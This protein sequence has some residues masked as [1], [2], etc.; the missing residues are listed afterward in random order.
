MDKDKY[1]EDLQ[2]ENQKLKKEKERLERGTTPSRLE[3]YQQSNANLKE[4]NK[5]L[6]QEIK[7]MKAENKKANTLASK[8]K[9]ELEEKGELEEEVKRLKKQSKK[10][11]INLEHLD[12]AQLELYERTIRDFNSHH[13][14]KI[15]D[16]PEDGTDNI[17]FDHFKDLCNQYP[18]KDLVREGIQSRINH[19][20]D[21]KRAE[22]NTLKEK[23]ELL[24]KVHQAQTNNPDSW[25]EE[26]DDKIISFANTVTHDDIEKKIVSLNSDIINIGQWGKL[27]TTDILPHNN[28]EMADNKNNLYYEILDEFDRLYSLM[29][30][31]RNAHTY[32]ATIYIPSSK[33]IDILSNL[34]EEVEKQLGLCQEPNTMEYFYNNGEGRFVRWQHNNT[35]LQAIQNHTTF[36]QSMKNNDLVRKGRII[37]SPHLFEKVPQW[38]QKTNIRNDNLIGFNNCF[39]NIN[40]HN[41]EPQIQPLDFNVPLL[42][43]RNTRTELYLN[44]NINGG[45]IEDIFNKCFTE[46]DAKSLLA[47]LGCCLYDKGYT[48]RQESIFLMSRGETGKTTLIK[49]FCEIFDKW[50]AQVVEKLSDD[51]FGLS[52]FS[53]NDCIIIDEVQGAKADFA[54]KLKS[55][56]TGSNLVIEQ[57]YKDTKNIPAIHVPR[58]WFIG[59]QFPQTLYEDLAGEGVFRRVLLIVPTM[60]IKDLGYSWEDLIK[61]NC[62]QWLVQQATK[63]YFENH[64]H[65]NRLPISFI[66][67]EEKQ[68][69]IKKCTYPERYFI[70]EHFEIVYDDNGRVVDSDDSRYYITYDQMHTFINDEIH[71]NMYETTIQIG[72]KQNFIKEFKKALSLPSSYNTIQRYGDTIFYGVR[73]ISEKAIEFMDMNK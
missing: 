10:K 59:N 33:E 44:D 67:D 68:S 48:Q 31:L 52:M 50:E 27:I 70:P 24:D 41:D 58:A 7:Q 20:K 62:Q 22:I 65:Q 47:Y 43:L 13:S 12:A 49:A 39:V 38:I 55:I 9:K 15:N 30:N 18:N 1:I 56:S 11:Y 5:G 51:K 66:S 34:A 17:I 64:M 45:A 54:Q 61:P 32:K 73:P 46:E 21:I 53:Q 36:V 3:T 57:K 4:T 19:F 8:F 23:A 71:N 63:I 29:T 16:F 14:D 40:P 2:K 69:R 6:R 42:P 37:S 25:E 35:I 26:F 72:N 28:T 60:P